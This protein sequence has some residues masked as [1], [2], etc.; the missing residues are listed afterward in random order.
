M[1]DYRWMY[2]AEPQV[3]LGLRSDFRRRYRDARLRLAELLA[4]G[5]EAGLARAEE[6]YRGLCA[7][8]PEDERL[9]MVLFHIHERTGSTLSAQEFLRFEL[10]DLRIVRGLRPAQTA[11]QADLR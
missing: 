7:E 11:G 3:A 10:D 8:D 4:R 5:P 9:W 1:R 2:D 6:L